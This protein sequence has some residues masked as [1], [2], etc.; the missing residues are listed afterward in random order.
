MLLLS[1]ISVGAKDGPNDIWS[2]SHLKEVLFGD[3]N[4]NWS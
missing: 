2:P 4:N 1:L 3:Q